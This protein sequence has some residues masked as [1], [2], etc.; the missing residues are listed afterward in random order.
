MMFSNS[1]LGIWSLPF[2]TTN[3]ASGWATPFH[4]SFKQQHNF[5]PQAKHFKVSLLN[6]L[7]LNSGVA[8]PNFADL[9][10]GGKEAITIAIAPMNYK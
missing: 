7:F 4:L 9:N 6:S 3:S 10:L 5:V 1:F 8:T 2:Q